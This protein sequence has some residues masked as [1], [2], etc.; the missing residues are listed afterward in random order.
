MATQNES[1]AIKISADPTQALEAIR[2][3]QDASSKMIQSL[4]A[5]TGGGP[6]MARAVEAHEK[7]QRARWGHAAANH[8]AAMRA[9]QGPV[10]AAGGVGGSVRNIAT[11]GQSVA[12]ML[13]ANNAT[14]TTWARAMGMTGS[15]GGAFAKAGGQIGNS[16]AQ[17]KAPSFA[18][19]STWANEAAK[20]EQ[21]AASKAASLRKDRAFWQT[22]AKQS[23]TAVGGGIMADAKIQM[24]AIDAELTTIR[25]TR[26]AISSMRQV[27]TGG[28][29]QPGSSS[30]HAGVSG[31][32]SSAKSAGKALNSIPFVG[33]LITSLGS[34]AAGAFGLGSV[35]KYWSMASEGGRA[36]ARAGQ[37]GGFGSYYSRIRGTS[38]VTGFTM[39]EVL[40]GL[41]TSQ[42]YSGN[43]TGALAALG[44]VAAYARAAGMTLP[45]AAQVFGQLS[46]YGKVGANGQAIM[47]GSS[48]VASALASGVDPRQF[49]TGTLN[50]AQTAGQTNASVSAGNLAGLQRSFD[51]LARQT[52][53]SMFRGS[54]G[55]NFL[56]G[57]QNAVTSGQGNPSAEYVTLQAVRRAY[58][59]T[60]GG[61]TPSMLH[62]FA[63]QSQGPLGWKN[64]AMVGQYVKAM[65][66][67]WHP[68]HS[69]FGAMLMAQSLGMPIGKFYSLMKATGGHFTGSIVAD[70]AAKAGGPSPAAAAA[71]YMASTPGQ[72]QSAQATLSRVVSDIGQLLSPKIVQLAQTTQL[73]DSAFSKM[74]K[75]LSSKGYGPASP[76]TGR[77]RALAQA[78]SRSSSGVYGVGN[79]N[80]DP[81]AF[82]GSQAA[83]VARMSPLAKAVSKTTGLPSTFVLGQWGMESGWG[84][85][86]S[87]FG[88]YNLGGIKAPGGGFASYNSLPAFAQGYTNFL[89]RNS[90]YDKLLA[91]ARSGAGL[92]TLETLMANSGYGGS[93]HAQYLTDLQNGVNSAAMGQ[94]QNNHAESV[95]ASHAIAGAIHSLHG[96]VRQLTV[97]QAVH[98]VQPN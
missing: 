47:P 20:F 86:G 1:I 92:N 18:A 34:L 85:Q 3:V 12:M 93:N 30:G 6:G 26:K 79:L 22:S 38:K 49:L 35:Q 62:T 68:N 44:P 91:A 55:A 4:G 65:R 48:V 8:A 24:A 80:P 41:S 50:L 27:L 81:A 5:S 19:V 96:T 57:F 76:Y 67:V 31:L 54:R 46:A 73:L 59:A 51:L 23:S 64:P 60:H 7:A 75:T 83:F 29:S 21:G 45:E 56:S 42:L 61:H 28:S 70:L 32:V 43:T 36:W 90:N 17:G 74:L 63:L 39:N 10:A 66:S 71:K 2:K 11:S 98:G 33:S 89:K 84:T 16:L 95:A 94:I 25:D 82:N 15:M 13:F 97:G 77:N 9:A 40:Q 14:A 78:M 52:G 88:G 53:L 72:I 58:A 87:G 37:P 69:T